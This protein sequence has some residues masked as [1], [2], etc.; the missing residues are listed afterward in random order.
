[1][2][3]R[4][5]GVKPFISQLSRPTLLPS[6]IYVRELNDK[7]PFQEK[8]CSFH[9]VRSLDKTAQIKALGYIIKMTIN[10]TRGAD[11]THPVDTWDI[12]N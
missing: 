4:W 9:F 7:R 10:D 8:P 3:C 12:Q 6:S 5:S 1:M 11:S 2:L